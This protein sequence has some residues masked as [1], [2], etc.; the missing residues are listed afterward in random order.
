MNTSFLAFK[1]R[2]RKAS[3]IRKNGQIFRPKMLGL[4]LYL[5]GAAPSKPIKRGSNGP[6]YEMRKKKRKKGKGKRESKGKKWSIKSQK[7]K[8]KTTTNK[9]KKNNKKNKKTNKK[10]QKKKKTKTKKQKTKKQQKN[11]ISF[12]FKFAIL[13]SCLYWIPEVNIQPYHHF[14]CFLEL[15]TVLRISSY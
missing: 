3:K 7:K 15:P 1:G 9:Q 4:L 5:R 6:A 10:K 14:D 12:V 13:I 11:N 2:A 8:E